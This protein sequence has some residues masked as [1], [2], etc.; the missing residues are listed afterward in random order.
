MRGPAIGRRG[1]QVDGHGQGVPDAEIHGLG[2]AARP[3]RVGVEGQL[4][5]AGVETVDV[6]MKPHRPL[7]EAAGQ[8]RLDVVAVVPRRLCP[9]GDGERLASPA[10]AGRPGRDRRR[11]TGPLGRPGRPRIPRGPSACRRPCRR[12]PG[13]RLRIGNDGPIPRPRPRRVPPASTRSPTSRARIAAKE[14]LRAFMVS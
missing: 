9:D 10:A 4:P 7:V 14:N 11:A 2:P 3:Q 13:R 12:S 6:E 5:I 8:K 1:A